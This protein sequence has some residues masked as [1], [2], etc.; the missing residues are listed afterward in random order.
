MAS[1]S[2][3]LYR[4]CIASRGQTQRE[5]RGETR[6]ESGEPEVKVQPL[7]LFRLATLSSQLSASFPALGS[8]LPFRPVC[9]FCPSNDEKDKKDARDD[10]GTNY[11][12][13][14]SSN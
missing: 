12:S 3:A 14:Y 9:P 4:T 10:L 8:P 1:C 5:K 13:K 7:S 6:D 11:N 2:Y